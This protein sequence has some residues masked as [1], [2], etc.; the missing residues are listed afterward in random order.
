MGRIK[1]EDLPED[2]KISKDEMKR[3]RGGSL[4]FLNQYFIDSYPVWMQEPLGV[5]AGVY[6]FSHELE[7][8]SKV[9]E[10]SSGGESQT[11]NTEL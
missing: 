1:I 3:L 6:R 11:M 7:L 9:V 10:K 4:N 2:Q 8:T 5:Q